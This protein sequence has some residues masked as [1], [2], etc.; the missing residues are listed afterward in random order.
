VL[1]RNWPTG[2][3]FESVIFESS[4]PPE[5]MEEGDDDLEDESDRGEYKECTVK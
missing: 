5:I 3:S 2:S 4:E 1:E